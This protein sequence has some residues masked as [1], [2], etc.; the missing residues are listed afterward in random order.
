M[1]QTTSVENQGKEKIETDNLTIEHIMPQNKNLSE[2]W[3]DMLGPNYEIVRNTYLHT[4]GNLTL[5]GYNSELGD[6]PFIEK[7][8]M[9]DDKK[10]KVVILYEDVKGLSEWNE[11]T[12]K[13]RADRLS[14]Q[15]VGLFSY[16]RPKTE[17]MFS[18]PDYKLYTCENPNDATFKSPNYFIINGERIKTNN[19]AE[20]LRITV[21]KLYEIDSSIIESMARAEDKIADWSSV[22]MFSYDQSKVQGDTKVAD[23]EIFQSVGFSASTIIC[24]IKGLLDRYGIDHEDFIYSAK[25]NKKPVGTPAYDGNDRSSQVRSVID[26]WAIKKDAEGSIHYDKEHSQKK[27]ARFTRD[28]ITQLIPD[29]DHA[30][31]DWGTKNHYFYEIVNNAG[32]TITMQIALNATN[33]SPDLMAVFDRINTDFPTNNNKKTWTWRVPFA[34]KGVDIPDEMT[35]E[36]ISH[37]LD[38]LYHKLMELEITF[39]EKISSI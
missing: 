35:E 15:I 28:G 26:R 4:L 16:E 3:Q 25:D 9:L 23:T 20:M 10:T 17:I 5:T 22:I 13:A 33:A 34:T 30:D 37:I 14:D 32:K 21:D 27:F 18:E 36:E 11:D 7:Q 19:F 29:S 31:S 12:I 1:L 39:V 2:E 8:E 24:I 6:K 38:D